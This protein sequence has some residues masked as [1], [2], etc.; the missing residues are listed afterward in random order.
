[1]TVSFQEERLA[2]VRD[3]ALPLLRRHWDE[4]ALDKDT[5]PL[6][7]DWERYARLEELGVFKV[8]TARRSGAS[9]GISDPVAGGR[10]ATPRG[11]LVGYASFF[12]FPNIHYKSLV[13]ADGDIFWVAPEHRDGTGYRLLKAAEAMLVASGVRKIVNKTKLG[14]DAGPVFE[15]LGYRAIERVY[16]KTVG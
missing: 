11:E 10:A 6:E 2:D 15:R 8:M 12:V 7:P 5:V 13:V 4:I 9:H 16:A 1:M 3:E 14:H